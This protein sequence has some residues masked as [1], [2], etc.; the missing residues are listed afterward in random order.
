MTDFWKSQRQLHKDLSALKPKNEPVSLDIYKR[1]AAE[2]YSKSPSQTIDNDWNLIL[3]DNNNKVYQNRMT[4]KVIHGISGSKTAGDFLNDGLQYM[5][6]WG[7]NP[8][9]KKRYGQSSDI[10]D[11]LNSIKKKREI[12]YASHSLGS[13]VSNRLLQHGKGSSAVNFNAFIPHES[14]NIDDDRV[15]NVRNKND[16]ASTITKHNNNTINLDN[17]SNPIKSHFISQLNL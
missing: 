15:V 3:N 13:N 11:R 4:G 2:S 6:G 1:I 5:V 7:N 17:D 8:L 12:E 14:L 10:V 9:Q 16:F